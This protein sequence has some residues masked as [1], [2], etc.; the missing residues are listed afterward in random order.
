MASHPESVESDLF[1]RPALAS[2]D[3]VAGFSTRNGGISEGAYA[4]LNLGLS[5]DDERE[6]VLT[7][8]R[9]LFEAAGFELD[10]MAMTGQVHGVAVH[11]VSAPGLY[12]GFDGLVTRT[13]GILLCLTAA[14][15][16]SVLMV[17]AA[18][19]VVGACHAGWRGVVGGIVPKTVREMQAMGAYPGQMAAYVSPSISRTHFEVGEEVAA[20][21]DAEFVHRDPGKPKPHVDL[22]AAITAQ[23]LEHYVPESSIEISGHCTYAE[24]D[25]FFSHRAEEGLT[26]RM[27]GFIG[28]RL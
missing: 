4:S 21:F 20:Q 8:R 11:G 1:I 5:T 22:K 23:L 7:N 18:S 27:I 14:D 25:R 2:G 9:R 15:C 17:D 24:T 26:G 6:R 28:L 16:A 3:V 19:G 13:R 10:K 12:R